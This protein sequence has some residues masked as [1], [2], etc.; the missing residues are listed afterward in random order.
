[1][2]SEQMAK[3]AGQAQPPVVQQDLAQMM[4]QRPMPQGMPQGAPQSAPQAPQAPQQ[5]APQLPEEQGIGTLPADNLQKMAGGGITGEQHFADQGAVKKNPIYGYTTL[6][7]ADLPKEISAEDQADYAR[8]LRDAAEL[9]AAPEQK[10]TAELY[11]PYIQK[12]QAKQADIEERKN[13][14]TQMALLQA[15]LGMLGGTSPYAFQNIA[16]GG[17]EGVAAY[18]SGKKAIEDSQDALDHAQ[19]LTAQA[20]NAAIKG[21]VKDQLALQNAAA[22][23]MQAH[24]QLQLS[25]KQILNTSRAEEGKLRAEAEGNQIKRDQLGIEST[26]AKSLGEL[27]AAEAKYYNDRQITAADKATAQLDARLNSQTSETRKKIADMIATGYAQPDAVNN[28]VDLHNQQVSNFYKAHPELKNQEPPLL[29]Y[30]NPAKPPELDWLGNPK[31]P[32]DP[33]APRQNA[34]SYPAAPVIQPGL[35]GL[36]GAQSTTAAGPAL[37]GPRSSDPNAPG[38]RFLG[39]EPSR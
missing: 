11:D 39:F 23:Q 14:N 7:E 22:S 33:N 27:Q 36:P 26:K 15:G 20:K 1:M 3:Q 9:Q 28:L 17:K 21:D 30:Y 10:R 2:R 13:T 24:Q 29:P 32:V 16:A 12:L 34:F 35:A 5:A 31:T 6:T 19:F 25:G 18:V 8:K 4:P 38:V 37:G